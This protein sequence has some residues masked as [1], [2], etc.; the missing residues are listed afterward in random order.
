[1]DLAAERA[2]GS[3]LAQELIERLDEASDRAGTTG[4]R[5]GQAGDEPVMSV[6]ARGELVHERHEVSRVLAHQRSSLVDAERQQLVVGTPAK[7]FLGLDRN[8]IVGRSPSAAAI[9]GE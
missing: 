5:R 2:F 6:A 3:S 4:H 9:R 1:V 7:L 8:D